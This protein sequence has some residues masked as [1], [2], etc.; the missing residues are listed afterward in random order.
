MDWWDAYRKAFPVTEK[1]VYMDAAYD[2][3]GSAIGKAA[4]ARHFEDWAHAAATAQRGGPGRDVFFEVAERCR[5][6]LAQ[7]LGGVETRN[8]AFTKNTNEGI[9]SIVQGFD[10]KPGDNVVT[11]RQE[12]PSLIMPCINVMEQRGIACRLADLPDD[13]QVPVDLLW[14][15]VDDRTAMVLVS[16]VQSRTGYKVDLQELGRR[17][18]ERGIFLI[19]DAVQ[20]MGLEAVPV[21]DWGVSAVCGAGYKGLGAFISIGY[22]YACDA[23]LARVR[24]TYVSHNFHLSLDFSADMPAMVCDDPLNASKL[25]NCSSDF[26]GI[27][28]LHDAVARINEIGIDNIAR[29]IDTL[30]HPLYLGLKALGYRIVTPEN[31]ERR[32]ASIAFTSEHCKEIIQYFFD[33]GVVIGGSTL[34][35]I[36]LGAFS[37]EA[38]VARTLAVAASCPFR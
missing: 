22:L 17:C 4:A 32:C 11:L 9:N 26:L 19:V 27:Y 14:D 5:A 6:H 37:N 16:H 38:D 21:E 33:H 34:V 13:M 25:D 15:K 1:C 3:G 31:P 2:C 18:R 12:Y 35:R 20:S 7:L 23:L 24:P 30:F 36:S 29:R 10:F 28:V 8:V